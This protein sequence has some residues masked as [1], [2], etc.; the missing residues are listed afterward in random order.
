MPPDK[1]PP[2]GGCC[3]FFFASD[4]ESRGYEPSFISSTSC[5]RV[6]LNP[7]DTGAPTVHLQQPAVSTPSVYYLMSWMKC[8]FFLCTANITFPSLLHL[9]SLISMEQYAFYRGRPIWLLMEVS[10]Q[11]SRSCL[12]SGLEVVLEVG[13]EVRV[14]GQGWRLCLR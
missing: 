5:L 12:K 3:C 11:G 13:L 1:K 8:F 10:G 7:P 6:V 2:G 9:S 4:C 14:G